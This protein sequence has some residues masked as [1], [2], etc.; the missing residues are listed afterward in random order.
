MT[1]VP[2]GRWGPTTVYEAGLRSAGGQL[3]MRRPDGRRDPLPVNRWR[4]TLSPAASTPPTWSTWSTGALS[5]GDLSLLRHCGG[6]TLDVGCGPGRLA[7]ALAARG[8]PALGIDVAPFAVHL[9]RRAGVPALRR[10]VFGRVPAEG[11]WVALL[12]ADGN[13][14]IG[15]DPTRL[16]RRAGELLAPSGRVL[17]ELEPP[18]T[19][20]GPM[21]VRLEDAT[22]RV[23]R[24]FS[25]CLVDGDDLTGIA[26]DAGLLITRTWCDAGRHFAALRRRL[27]TG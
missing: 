6:P 11:R 1:G 15:G 7:A 20:T 26:P 13:I 21:R 14:G 24:P 16:L 19:Q 3:W 2:D 23:S 27:P 9:T 18:G 17:V 4:G 25:W 10:D 12:L 8:V 22:G 5:P